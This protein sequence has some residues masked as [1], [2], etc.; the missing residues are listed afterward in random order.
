MSRGYGGPKHPQAVDVTIT[1][2]HGILPQ[3]DP[4]HPLQLPFGIGQVGQDAAQGLGDRG[5]IRER[6]QPYPP[7]TPHTPGVVTLALGWAMP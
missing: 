2:Q 3:V 1:L 6:A 7:C 4:D 5:T